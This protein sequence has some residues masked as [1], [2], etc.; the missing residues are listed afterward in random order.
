MARKKSKRN[1][2]KN[3]EPAV[4]SISLTFPGIAGQ[5]QQ[6][7]DLSQIASLINRRFYRQGLNWAVAGFKIK[8]VTGTSNASIVVSKLPNTWVMA[9][10]WEKSFRTWNQMIKESVEEDLSLKPRFL[11]FK[12]FA[13]SQHHTNGSATNLLPLAFDGTPATPGDWDYST[14]HVPDTG[15]TTGASLATVNRVVNEFDL[16]ATG[17]SYP[18]A[19]ASGNNAVSLIEGYASSRALPNV[20]DPNTPDDA[21]SITGGTPQNWMEAIFNEGMIQDS[22]VVRDLQ[23]QNEI[24]PY[25]FENDGTN[26]D[27]MYPNGA[28]QLSGVQIHDFVDFTN[29]TI[30]GT[31]YVKGG[32]FPCGLIRFDAFLPAG[33]A[34]QTFSLII[35]LV[36]G[37]HRGYMAET[38]TEM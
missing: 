9:N 17:G 8:N 13:D 35:D 11:D 19:G 34:P 1:G 36:P 18:G 10:S 12:V 29:T 30:S 14:I 38:M 15:A 33:A 27:T 32:N 7:A 24:A 3:I 4:M 25:P 22:E 20:L 21:R 6:Y 31:G 5:S 37:H 23:T 2:M 26:P 28:N 16:I